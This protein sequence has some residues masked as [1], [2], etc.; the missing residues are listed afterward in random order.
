MNYDG[1]IIFDE[2]MPNGILRK[3]SINDKFKT[4]FSNHK[5][6]QLSDGLKI[7]IDHF[8]E[9]YPNIRL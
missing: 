4:I 9:K 6:T 7:T 2:N 8:V 5:F 3:P 1:S